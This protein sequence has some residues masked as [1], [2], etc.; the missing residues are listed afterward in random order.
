M[1]ERNIKFAFIKDFQGVI[2]P[3]IDKT[4]TTTLRTCVFFNQFNIEL[5]YRFWSK[6]VA[7]R[8]KKS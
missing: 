5:F 1:A 2:R 4:I 6:I 3:F 8:F 7:L